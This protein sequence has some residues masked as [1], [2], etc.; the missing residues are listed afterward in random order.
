M[1]AASS[2]PALIAHL[3]KLPELAPYHAKGLLR[4]YLL[5]LSR[6]ELWSPPN[7]ESIQELGRLVQQEDCSPSSQLPSDVQRALLRL[8]APTTGTLLER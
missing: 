5:M 4:N 7:Q 6:P 1:A 8:L 3:S 2:D